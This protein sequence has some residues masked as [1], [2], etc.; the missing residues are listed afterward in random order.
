M[1]QA[2]F[3]VSEMV[4][5]KVYDWSYHSKRQSEIHC[6]PEI[7]SSEFRPKVYKQSV[8]RSMKMRIRKW[9]WSSGKW[10]IK[11]SRKVIKGIKKKK[12]KKKRVNHD[13]PESSKIV[14]EGSSLQLTIDRPSIQE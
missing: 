4:E 10:S 13:E 14:F 11:C 7:E 5:A 8:K 3:V 12:K 2:S 1:N 6:F 9:K